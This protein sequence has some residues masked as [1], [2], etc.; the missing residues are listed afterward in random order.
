MRALTSLLFYSAS[1]RSLFQY[2]PS[3]LILISA[4][5]KAHLTNKAATISNADKS[6]TTKAPTFIGT[7]NNLVTIANAFY[8]YKTTYSASL[9]DF[10]SF[11]L[12]STVSQCLSWASVNYCENC[13][14][15]TLTKNRAN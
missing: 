6:S 5:V 2:K 9:D 3:Q 11:T 8:V 7:F 13:S 15:Q 10:S 1:N 4:K 14:P 12:L